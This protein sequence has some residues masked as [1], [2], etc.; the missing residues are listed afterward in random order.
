MIYN[1]FDRKYVFSSE[2]EMQSIHHGGNSRKELQEASTATA[3]AM[4]L[5]LFFFELETRI[6]ISKMIGNTA[7]LEQAIT[8]S[9]KYLGGHDVDKLWRWNHGQVQVDTRRGAGYHI[10]T[11]G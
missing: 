4:L 5:P 9:K 1:G 7:F 6:F 8:A 10:E 11:A 3:T 2:L